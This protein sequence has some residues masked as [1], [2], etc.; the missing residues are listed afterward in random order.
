MWNSDFTM[1]CLTKYYASLVLQPGAQQ[2]GTISCALEIFQFS[3]IIL[4]FRHNWA[5]GDLFNMFS[6][7]RLGTPSSVRH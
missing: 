3:T 5:S 2:S 1:D 6:L 7:G 4:M